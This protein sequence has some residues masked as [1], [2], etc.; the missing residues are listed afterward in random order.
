MKALIMSDTHG[1]IYDMNRIITTIKP[2][3]TLHCG[4]FCVDRSDLPLESFHVVRGNCDEPSDIPLQK[5]VD[6]NG[7]RF[8]LAHGHEL[9]VKTSLLPLKYK[10]MESSAGIA[11]FGHSHIPYCEQEND[12]LFINPGSVASPRVFKEPTFVTLDLLSTDSSDGSL[13]V[14][15]SYFNTRF[16]QKK[17]LGGRF[18]LNRLPKKES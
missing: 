18:R 4:D 10:A 11:L 2:N 6:W 8:F 17:E 7:L 12:I 13:Q 14:E 3:I 5:T 9:Q 16:E 1:L 15:I